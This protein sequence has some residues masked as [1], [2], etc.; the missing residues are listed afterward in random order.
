MTPLDGL[1]EPLKGLG[2]TRRT[3][4]EEATI[5]DLDGKEA[6]DHRPAPHSDPDDAVK[7]CFEVKVLTN[8]LIAVRLGPVEVELR[9]GH[10]QATTDPAPLWKTLRAL[11]QWAERRAWIATKQ[12]VAPPVAH[13]VGHV[14]PKF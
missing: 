6:S 1:G 12:R 7:R 14:V 13:I 2:E 9:S 5:I 11:S 4:V 8:I 3:Q 10:R